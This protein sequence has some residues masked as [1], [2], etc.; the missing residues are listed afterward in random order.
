LAIVSGLL[1]VVLFA[2]I[3]VLLYDINHLGIGYFRG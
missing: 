3:C 2:I 1:I